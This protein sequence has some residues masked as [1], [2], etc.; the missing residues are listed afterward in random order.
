MLIAF[1][2]VRLLKPAIYEVM[3]TAPPREVVERVRVVAGAVAGV[4]DIE[5]CLIRKMGL[6]FYVDLHV[7]VN[8]DISVRDGH[9]IAHLV[10]NAVRAADP[11]IADVLVHIEPVDGDVKNRRR[12]F[13]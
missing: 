9:H 11:A 10:K 5:R 3:D 7:G 8:G 2:G 4:A 1:N 6:E 12:S 13:P